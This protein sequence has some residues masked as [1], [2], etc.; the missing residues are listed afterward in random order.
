M[1]SCI[2]RSTSGTG[3]FFEFAPGSTITPGFFSLHGLL[4]LRHPDLF[5]CTD[6]HQWFPTS[7]PWILSC[8][9]F[10]RTPDVARSN[11]F[12]KATLATVLRH[13]SHHSTEFYDWTDGST[14]FDIITTIPHLRMMI[15]CIVPGRTTG[16]GWE[17]RFCLRASLLGYISRA[18]LL[19][20]HSATRWI[21]L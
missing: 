3:V 9:F 14:P 11:C 8:L 2:R 6:C 5:A 7:R 18:T 12:W 4:L 17:K 20:G 13:S 10:A 19:P 21:S 1:G 16:A 15:C